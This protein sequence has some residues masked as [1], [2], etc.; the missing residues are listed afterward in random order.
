MLWMLLLTLLKWLLDWLLKGTPTLTY[1]Q[2]DQLGRMLYR[3][4]RIQHLANH[5]G[6]Q[7][8]DEGA[9]Q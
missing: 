3:M 2:R 1:A 7:A 4:D 9:E 5:Y 8:V 6:I